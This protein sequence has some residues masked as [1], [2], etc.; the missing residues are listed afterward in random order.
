MLGAAPKQALP[1]SGTAAFL[2]RVLRALLPPP[3]LGFRPLVPKTGLSTRYA[4][5]LCVV[6]A[7]APALSPG[8]YG[9]LAMLATTYAVLMVVSDFGLDWSNTAFLAACHAADRPGVVLTQLKTRTAIVGC[10][11]IIVVTGSWFVGMGR[12]YMVMVAVVT[13]NWRAN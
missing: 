6:V 12:E 1:V 10:A 5:V 3:G 7:L 11:A 9:Q 2:R 4:A 8:Q 13:P